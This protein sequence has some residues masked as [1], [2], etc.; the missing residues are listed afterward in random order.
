MQNRNYR[1]SSAII[2]V[3][4]LPLLRPT[5]KKYQL[6]LARGWRE[7]VVEGLRFFSYVT[8]L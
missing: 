7:R 3:T 4:A 1:P 5:G 6:W 8:V 2:R